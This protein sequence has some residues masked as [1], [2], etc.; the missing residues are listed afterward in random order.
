[1]MF[2]R[3]TQLGSIRRGARQGKS[4]V[5]VA[6]PTRAMRCC[7]VLCCAEMRMAAS[8]Q[9]QQR[10]SAE[11]KTG[12]SMHTRTRAHAASIATRDSRDIPTAWGK[13]EGRTL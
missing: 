13:K 10:S 3:T 8:R 12:E 9:Q 11:S 2:L 4:R 1:M 6:E 5:S 7:A